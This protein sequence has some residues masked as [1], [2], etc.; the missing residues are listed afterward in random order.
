MVFYTDSGSFVELEVSN[1][2]Q[3]DISNGGIVSVSGSRGPLVTINDLVNDPI[4]FQVTSASIDIFEIDT[5]K[6]VHI[7]GSLIVS[8]GFTASAEIHVSAGGVSNKISQLVFSNS[9]N[10]SFG[11]NGS[12]LTATY[13][14]AI[15]LNYYNP[16]N[17]YNQ[18][19]GTWGVGSLFMQPFQSP[20]D[21]N[22]DRLAMPVFMSNAAN[23]NSTV[24]L[25]LSMRWGLYTRSASTLNLLTD[26]STVMTF[27]NTLATS[28]SSIYHGIRLW[29]TDF[30]KTISQGQYYVAILSNQTTA[31]QPGTISNIVIS[32]LNSSFWGIWGQAA[33]QSAQ[34]TRGLGIYSVTTNALPAAIA[35]NELRGAA[36]G[37]ATVNNTQTNVLRQPIFYLVNNTY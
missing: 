29:T 24:A 34:Y 15:V 25:T 27:Q 28:N 9:N 14:P 5:Q 7:S 22:C 2:L 35:F 26:Y 33:A 30:S 10:F 32:Q 11:L 18:V 36:T 37:T 6:N 19:L 3:T 20:Y 17:A 21:V 1:S 4:V 13:D 31:N 12:T 8:G 23:N 16:L